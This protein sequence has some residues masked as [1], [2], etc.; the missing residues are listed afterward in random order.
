MPCGGRHGT[1]GRRRSSIG[2]SLDLVNGPGQDQ[3]QD[4]DGSASDEGVFRVVQHVE[5]WRCSADFSTIIMTS[6]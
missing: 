4:T 3:Q 2:K 6:L 1:T 5:D